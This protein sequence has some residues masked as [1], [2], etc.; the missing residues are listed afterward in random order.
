MA[1]KF[2]FFLT[3]VDGGLSGRSNL[4]RPGSEN[5]HRRQRKFKPCFSLRLPVLYLWSL[6]IS[7]LAMCITGTFG[8]VMV[9]LVI[10]RWNML[11]AL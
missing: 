8:N 6:T 1:R 7:Y 9:C 2:I 3:G 10:A 5:P 4:R 11:L